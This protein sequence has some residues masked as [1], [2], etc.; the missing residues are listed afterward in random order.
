[1]A[2]TSKGRRQRAIRPFT[3]TS[4]FVAR[5]LRARIAATRLPDK[6]TVEDRRRASARHD[7]CLARY[8]RS[9]YDRASARRGDAYP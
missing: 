7:P 5:D 2:V 6:E 9:E 1:M 8:C 3:S 4:R